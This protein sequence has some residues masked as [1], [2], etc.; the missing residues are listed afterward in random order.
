[1]LTKEQ[2][3]IKNFLK[4]RNITELY[5]FTRIENLSSILEN[6]ILSIQSLK[7]KNIHYLYND[8]YRYDNKFNA[9]CLSISFPNYKMFYLARNNKPGEWCVLTLNSSIL[10][11]KPCLFCIQNAA[12][13]F[14]TNR[15]DTEKQGL[16]GLKKL[17]FDNDYRQSVNLPLQF[18][19]NPQA[20]VLVLEDIEPSYIT[21]INF[22]DSDISFNYQSYPNFK[23]YEY[24]KLFSYRYDYENWR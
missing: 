20:E 10:Y 22:K 9:N 1:M 16:D 21:S 17:F 6:G 13:N 24:P 2:K 11:K 4:S 14:E 7:S 3:E 19:T 15:P 23:F 5:H 8:D 18:T 12:S